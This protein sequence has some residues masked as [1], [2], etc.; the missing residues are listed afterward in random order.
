MILPCV[1]ARVADKWAKKISDL[2][3]EMDKM[4]LLHANEMA[5]KTAVEIDLRG[6]LSQMVTTTSL[7][8]QAEVGKSAMSHAEQRALAFR[9]GMAYAKELFKEMRAIS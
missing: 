1:P 2:Q 5:L 6:Q 3:A 8:V 7:T 4:R 9:E